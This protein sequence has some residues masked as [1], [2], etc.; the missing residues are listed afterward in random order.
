M[1]TH[2]FFC[3]TATIREGVLPENHSVA[4]FYLSCVSRNEG[5][6]EL[7]WFQKTFRTDLL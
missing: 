6:V 5:K 1:L 7:L 2:T 4:P 3:Q